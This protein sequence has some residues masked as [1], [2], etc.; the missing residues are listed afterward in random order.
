MD[1]GPAERA[2]RSVAVGRKNYLFVG[3]QAGGERA[4]NIYTVLSTCKLLGLDPQAYLRDVFDK[5][6]NGWKANRFDELLPAQ[7][8]A[9]RDP[10]AKLA[11]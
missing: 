4:A 1:N 7:W 11:A 6:I 5:I 8:Q 9:S 10:P 3:S 2:I